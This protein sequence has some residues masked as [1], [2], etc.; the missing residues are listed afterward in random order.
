[1]LY[2]DDVV[3]AVCLYLE[4]YGYTIRQSL[5]A[6]DRGHDII[7][8]KQ[9]D[10]RWELYIEA[11]GEG[12]SKDSTARFGKAF[13]SGQV[14]DHV[15]KAVLKALR[16]GSLEGSEPKKRAGIALPKN[17]LHLKEIEMVVPALRRAGI[18]VFL[19]D[20]AMHVTVDSPWEL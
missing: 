7:A 10:P 4:R 12:S 16:V 13:N 6:R 5:T 3:N 20:E 2:E 11:K 9:T 14:F 8:E 1:M 15:A 18:A 17:A 19:V